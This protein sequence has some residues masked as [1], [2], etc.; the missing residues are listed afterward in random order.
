MTDIICPLCGKPNPPD[1]DEC[2]YCQAPLKTG[3][4]IASPESESEL[5]SSPS[6][7]DKPGEAEN[8]APAPA[9]SSDLEQNIPD[10]LKQTEADFLDL[11]E[12]K[13]EEPYPGELSDQFDSLLS[14]PS[15]PPSSQETAI[16]DDWLA[17]LLEEAGVGK[18]N[19]LASKQAQKSKSPW[20]NMRR[21]FLRESSESPVEGSTEG[22][23]PPPT[24]PVEKPA[25]LT[26]LEA[27]STIKMEGELFASEPGPM[28]AP[29][30]E[31]Q[32]RKKVRNNQHHQIGFQSRALKKPHQAPRNRKPQLRRPNS[33]AGW[34]PSALPKQFRLLDRLRIYQVQILSRQDL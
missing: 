12:V 34:K 32:S 14:P 9:A 20:K 6:S 3:G 30:E 31:I 2:M 15:T 26:S 7:S 11:S 21:M 17:S 23:Q 18:P 28:E 4:F 29:A 27:S 1:L 22:K 19:N 5:G 8:K 25:W 13:P 16:D 10:W 24:T 33:L